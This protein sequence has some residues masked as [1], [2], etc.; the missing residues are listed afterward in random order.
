MTQASVLNDS[1]K[2]FLLYIGYGFGLT[3]GNP[4]MLMIVLDVALLKAVKECSCSIRSS[5][6]VFTF[7]SDVYHTGKFL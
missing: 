3:S 1:Y 4:L 6:S 5:L 7:P 2:G